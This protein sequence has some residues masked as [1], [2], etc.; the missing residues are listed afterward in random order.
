MFLKCAVVRDRHVRTTTYLATNSG[1]YAKKKKIGRGLGRTS[2]P[3]AILSCHFCTMWW[4]LIS[5]YLP[6]PDQWVRWLWS[7]RLH[8]FCAA[9]PSW[10]LHNPG[11]LPA[12]LPLQLFADQPGTITALG[13]VVHKEHGCWGDYLLIKNPEKR[14]YVLNF[15]P[16]SIMEIWVHSKCKFSSLLSLNWVQ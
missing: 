12:F 15:S 9:Q 1:I 11:A 14:W 5:V 2:S 16:L 8:T 6:V 3:G 13:T 4:Q 10:G 7:P